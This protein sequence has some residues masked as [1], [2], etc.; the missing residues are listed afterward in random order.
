[1][2]VLKLPCFVGMLR[3]RGVLLNRHIGGIGTGWRCVDIAWLSSNVGG[4]KYC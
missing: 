2:G 1:M 4:W 3:G